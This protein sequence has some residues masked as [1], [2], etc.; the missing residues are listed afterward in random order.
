MR[1]NFDVD[2]IEEVICDQV[3]FVLADCDSCPC[4]EACCD[5]GSAGNDDFFCNFELDFHVVAGLNCRSWWEGC[6]T[7]D[8][9]P[10][11][12]GLA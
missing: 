5:E 12:K 1:N 3:P 2:A 10:V 7:S 11:P 8:C 4:C 6:S 9:D